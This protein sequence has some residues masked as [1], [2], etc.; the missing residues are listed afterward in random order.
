MNNQVQKQDQ[1]DLQ[2]LQAS[3]AGDKKAFSALYR[4]YYPL[5]TRFAYRYLKQLDVIEEV[6]NDTLL[7]TWQKASDFRGESRVS[8]WIMGIGMRKCWEA[9]RKLE[10][11]A[12]Q[13]LDA[14]PEQEATDNEVERWDSRQ[15]IEQAMQHLSPEQRSCVEL[16]YQ[17]GYTCEEI[18]QIMECPA[19]T[20]KTRLFHARKIFKRVFGHDTVPIPAVKGETP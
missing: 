1:L 6:V 11:H 9:A 16:A 15:E 14:V 12:S 2:L 7:T 10:K 8:T 4:R 20:V 18:G 5:L 17:S 3:G 13:D 19:N